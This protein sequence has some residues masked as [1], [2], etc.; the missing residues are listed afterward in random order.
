MS[1]AV[2]GP[3]SQEESGHPK[4]KKKKKK[5]TMRLLVRCFVSSQQDP[6]FLLEGTPHLLLLLASQNQRRV[7]MVLKATV[8]WMEDPILL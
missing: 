1:F 7:W 4:K 5:K 2:T 8:R 3:L 6:L